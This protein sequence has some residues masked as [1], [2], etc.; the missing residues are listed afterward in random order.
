M[1]ATAVSAT[2]S[3]V[4]RWLGELRQRGE[5]VMLGSGER[6]RICVVHAHAHHHDERMTPSL[7]PVAQLV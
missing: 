6:E 7:A 2:R 4:T 5:L 3:T 1:L